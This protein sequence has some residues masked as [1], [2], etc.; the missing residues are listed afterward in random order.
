M[1]HSI[2]TRLPFLDYRLVEFAISI[3]INHKIHSGWTKFILRNAVSD[4]LPEEIV[5][6]KN[7]LGFEAP[8]SIW[9]RDHAESMKDQIMSS[10]I[11]K[12]IS[13]PSAI[14]K[15]FNSLSLKDRWAYFNLAAWERIYNV[16]WE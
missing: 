10:A 13:N 11:L 9:L 3:P 6:R 15:N 5:W 12:K 7:K 8:A 1:R 16:A 14:T 2:E 4:V